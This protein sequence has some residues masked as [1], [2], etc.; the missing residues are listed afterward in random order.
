MI[1]VDS[2]RHLEKD[3]NNDWGWNVEINKNFNYEEAKK[4]F[5]AEEQRRKGREKKYKFRSSI[6]F[7]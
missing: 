3:N 4:E 6:N 5:M 1:D 2:F 7:S